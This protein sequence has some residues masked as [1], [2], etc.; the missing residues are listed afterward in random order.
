MKAPLVLIAEDDPDQSEQACHVL[1]DAG[2]R[3][4]VLHH[5]DEVLPKA[6][7]LNPNLLIMD[8]RMPGLNGMQVLKALR[9]SAKFSTLAVILISAYYSEGELERMKRSGANGCL[10]KPFEMK[11]LLSEVQRIVGK[12]DSAGTATE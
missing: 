12:A 5:G 2:Y 10:S 1:A 8:V 4:Q 6:E 11:E 7:L 3:V 9:Q